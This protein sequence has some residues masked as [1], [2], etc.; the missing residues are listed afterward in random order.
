MRFLNRIFTAFDAET[1]ARGLEKIK[2]IGDAYMVA[3]GV[4][5]AREDHADA[6]AELALG[7]RDATS[8]IARELGLE[9]SVRIGIHSGDLVGGV[10]GQAGAHSPLAQEGQPGVASNLVGA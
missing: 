9:L 5:D 2:T 3:A 1:D 8:N 7:I 10:I 4:P 6:M